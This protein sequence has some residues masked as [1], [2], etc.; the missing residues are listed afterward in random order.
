MGSHVPGAG[1]RSFSDIRH[2]GRVAFFAFFVFHSR[3]KS[4]LAIASF[5]RLQDIVLRKRS[6]EGSQDNLKD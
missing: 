3:L 6:G 5:L 1:V 2:L 4:V